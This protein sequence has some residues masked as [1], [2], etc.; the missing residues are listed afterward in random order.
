MYSNLIISYAVNVYSTQYHECQKHKD[1]I[2]IL[3]I[4]VFLTRAAELGPMK[5]H[6]IDIR[7]TVEK[8]E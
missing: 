2:Q 8:Q 3:Y 4:I 1:G 5:V 6:S 7:K